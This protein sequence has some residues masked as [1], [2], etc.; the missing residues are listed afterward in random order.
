M[1][2][3]IHGWAPVFW[4]RVAKNGILDE[5][6]VYCLLTIICFDEWFVFCSA[7][8]EQQK[9]DIK[10]CV[11][12]RLHSI[13]KRVFFFLIRIELNLCVCVCFFQLDFDANIPFQNLGGFSWSIS[14]AELSFSFKI[15]TRAW[16]R[17][18]LQFIYIHH[19]VHAGYH[20]W[21]VL[22]LIW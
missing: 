11:Q 4:L 18:R 13:V 3:S 19:L 15:T 22:L 1:I 20:L 21:C 8:D 7:F 14:R 9:C 16:Q 17:R 6:Y 12:H 2:T 10:T 5:R